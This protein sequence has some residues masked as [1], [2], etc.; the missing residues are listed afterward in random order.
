[1]SPL[2]LHEVVNTLELVLNGGVG[3]TTHLLG[4][5][6]M[7]L[8]EDRAAREWLREDFSRLPVACEEYLR[9]FAPVPGLARTVMTRCELGG[10]TL[11]ENERI[12]LNWL[13][14]NHDPQLF[15]EPATLKL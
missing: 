6:L 4:N 1:G 12:W 2:P 15:D 13:A 5:A 9:Y 10:Q 7:H 14:A 3:S 11:E 8:N